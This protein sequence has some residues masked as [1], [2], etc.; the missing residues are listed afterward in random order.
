MDDDWFWCYAFVAV[1]SIR[2]HP[3]ND[4]DFWREE[5]ELAAAVADEMLRL[6]EERE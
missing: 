2:L 1:A 6:K 3:R 5:V 4:S